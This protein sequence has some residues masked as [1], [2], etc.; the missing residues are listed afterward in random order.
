MS[1]ASLP[2]SDDELLIL[3]NPRCSKSRATLALLQERGAAVAVRE[4]LKDPLTRRELA[5]LA[6]RLGRPASGFVRRKEA[7]FA[8]AG[9]DA[10]SSDDAILDAMAAAPVLMERPILVRGRRA[11]IGRPPEDVLQLL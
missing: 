10:K 8:E 6:G 3:H 11:A 1:P 5:D 2:A 7:A 4:Y 9:L